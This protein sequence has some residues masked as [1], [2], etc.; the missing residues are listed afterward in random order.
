MSMDILDVYLKC[1]DFYIFMKS[2]EEQIEYFKPLLSALT[3]AS[4]IIFFSTIWR[5]KEVREMRFVAAHGYSR[6]WKKESASLE[7][8]LAQTLE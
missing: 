2:V 3:I 6:R 7:P 4:I 8:E 1:Q 5:L